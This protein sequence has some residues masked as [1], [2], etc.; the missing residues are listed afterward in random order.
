V[1]GKMF[2]KCGFLYDFSR[3]SV[4]EASIEWGGGRYSSNVNDMHMCDCA[5]TNARGRKESISIQMPL[6]TR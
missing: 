1:Q 5:V 6:H 4:R 2:I 3:I